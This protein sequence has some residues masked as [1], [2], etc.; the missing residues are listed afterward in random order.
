MQLRFLRVRVD[1]RG[2]DH[3]QKLVVVRHA[4]LDLL[5]QL[6]VE[7]EERDFLHL[8]A[9]LAALGKSLRFTNLQR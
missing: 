9:S 7:T 3:L 1:S 4:G 5:P 2:D 6:G 8:A